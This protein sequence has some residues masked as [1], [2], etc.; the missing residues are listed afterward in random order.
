MVAFNFMRH[1]EPLLLDGTKIHT[2]RD[3]ARAN[4]GDTLQLFTGQRTKKCRLIKV[5]K[6][7]AVLPVRFGGA[8][9]WSIDGRD[10]YDYEIE[11]F[12]KGDG[13]S[14]ND[15]MDNWFLEAK[16]ILPWHGFLIAWGE[17][18]YMPIKKER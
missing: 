14:C 2:L 8:M 15:E 13:F 3:T 11:K 18:S 16:K 9:L 12:A 5:E 7:T 10:L 1:F 17:A 6:C 4:V